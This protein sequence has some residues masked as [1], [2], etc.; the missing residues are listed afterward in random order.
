MLAAYRKQLHGRL[1]QADLELA[2][3][4][5]ANDHTPV[6]IHEIPDPLQANSHYVITVGRK[7][8]MNRHSAPRSERKVF[9]HTIILFEVAGKLER[10]DGRTHG[11]IPNRKAGDHTRRRQISLEKS[12]RHGEHVPVVVK[13]VSRV[14][15]G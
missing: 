3:Q 2:F 15:G 9:A 4:G 7:I 1:I 13:S 5:D 11:T 10:L 12:G 8:V 14:V 6:T